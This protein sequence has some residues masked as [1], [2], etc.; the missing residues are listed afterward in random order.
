MLVRLFSTL[1]GVFSIFSSS[2][3]H[4]A[5]IQKQLTLRAARYIGTGYIHF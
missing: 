3:E 4:L 2:L 1:F 5:S